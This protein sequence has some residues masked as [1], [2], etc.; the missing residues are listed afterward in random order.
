M[1]SPKKLLQSP[2]G[3]LVIL[4]LVILSLQNAAGLRYNFGDGSYYVGS[5]D[6]GGRPSGLGKYFDS[7]G[8]LGKKS[9]HQ[10]NG[11]QSSKSILFLEY[12]GE[13]AAGLRHGQ[14]TL[15]YRSGSVYHGQFRYGKPDGPGV[16][17]K[18]N[19]DQIIG[20]YSP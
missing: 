18:K 8:T 15:Y 13:F 11:S 6:K 16:L 3:Y 10:L 9:K 1:E 2:R 12:E 20:N 17:K 14:G 7:S 19:G 5:V 4:I